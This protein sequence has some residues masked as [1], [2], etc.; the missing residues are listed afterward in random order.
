MF[1]FAKKKT[2]K[3]FMNIYLIV[4]CEHIVWCRNTQK[5]YNFDQFKQMSFMQRKNFFLYTTQYF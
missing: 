4:L 5:N 3:I 2:K 1:H